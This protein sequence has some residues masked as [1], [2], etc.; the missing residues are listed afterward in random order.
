MSDPAT[1]PAAPDAAPQLALTLADAAQTCRL[2][3][4]LGARLRAGDVVLLEGPIGAGK[5]HFARCLIQSLLELPEDV[6][7][8][9]YTLVQVY[10]TRAGEVWHADLYRAGGPDEVVELGLD[11]AFD[12]AICLVEWP[13][14]LGEL[15]PP[16]ALT[17]ALE[18][19]APDHPAA[20][21]SDA[22]DA[23]DAEDSPRTARLSWTDPG[24]D[25]RLEGIADD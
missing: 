8:P 9:T 11:E 13:D 23:S 22:S 25:A 5:T 15:A 12:Q 16:R 20:I 24:W 2:A 3:G 14:R 19:Q 4:R 1:A 21:A 18:A 7:S 6:P 17:L 10:Q